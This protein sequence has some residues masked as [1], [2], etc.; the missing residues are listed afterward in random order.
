M[1]NKL[2]YLYFLFVLYFNHIQCLEKYAS[3]FYKPPTAVHRQTGYPWVCTRYL[4]DT[5]EVVQKECKHPGIYLIFVNSPY[6]YDSIHPAVNQP[7]LYIGKSM[8]NVNSRFDGNKE[9]IYK[10]I[11][12]QPAIS[13]F[14]RLKANCYDEKGK[15]YNSDAGHIEECLLMKFAT[16]LNDVNGFRGGVDTLRY[17]TNGHPVDILRSFL[18]MDLNNPGYLYRIGDGDGTNWYP[19]GLLQPVNHMLMVSKDSNTAPGTSSL[20]IEYEGGYVLDGDYSKFDRKEMKNGKCEVDCKSNRSSAVDVNTGSVVKFK[21]FSCSAPPVVTAPPV[22]TAPPKASIFKRA[23]SW[24][25]K[26]GAAVVGSVVGAVGSGMAILEL[27]EIAQETEAAAAAAQEV[28][29]AVQVA[30]VVEPVPEVANVVE[31]VPEVA[32]VVEPV[33]EVA[34]VVEPAPKVANVKPEYRIEVSRGSGTGSGSGSGTG[35]RTVTSGP[36]TGGTGR[37]GNRPYDPNLGREETVTRP[38]GV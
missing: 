35:S 9:K 22:I 5:K 21:L 20:C 25:A 11:G 37:V 32:N 13:C 36:Q 2:L 18:N 29:S 23:G 10:S 19:T 16:L 30:N 1:F 28:K 3:K 8:V 14:M 15:E 34:N 7:L 17:G 4:D 26:K 6:S 31:T 38:P 24:I 33:P 12:D 27:I